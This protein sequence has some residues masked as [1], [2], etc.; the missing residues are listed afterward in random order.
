MADSYRLRSLTL[1]GFRAYLAPKTFDFGT[2]R[3]L[4]VFA[5]NGKGKSSIVDGLEFMFS[6]EGTLERLGIRTIHN[7]A[8]VVALAHNLAADRGIDSSV[9]VKFTCGKEE[10]SGKRLTAGARRRPAAAD[11]V[12]TGFVVDPIVRGY[13]LRQFVEKRTAED[14]YEDVARWLELGSLV[15]AQNSLRE[16]RRKIKAAA[17]DPQPLKQIDGQLS[18]KTGNAVRAWHDASVLAYANK[19]IAALNTG[20]SLSTLDPADPTAVTISERAEAEAKQLGLEGLRQIRRAAASLAEQKQSKDGSHVVGLIAEFEADITT[21]AAAAEKVETEKAIAADAIFEDVW[22][23]AEPLFAEGAEAPDACPICAT[24]IAE[25]KAGSVENIRAHIAGHRA[26]LVAYADARKAFENAATELS[27][28][29]TRF[30]AALKALLPL[31]P[32]ARATLKQDLSTYL[33]SL[34]AWTEGDPPNSAVLIGGLLACLTELDNEIATI[35]A[36]QG[37]NTYTKV[38]AKLTELIELRGDRLLAQRKLD[39][40]TKLHAALVEQSGFIS[41]QIRKKVQAVLD[42]LQTPVNTIYKEIQRDA[43]AP[44][45]LELPAEEDLNQQRLHLVVDF[46]TNRTG[47]QPSGYLSDS[48]IHSLALALRL[49]AIKRC[50]VT[51]PLVVL[52]DIVTSYDADHRLAFSALLAKEFADL[53]IIVVT[54]D[55]RFFIYL[56]DHLGDRDWHYIRIMQL[57]PAYGPRFVDHR[58]SDEM[59]EARWAAG[60]SAANDMRQAE[61]EW[62]LGICREFGVDVRIRTVERAYSYERSELAEALARFLGS[63]GLTPPTVPGV[64]NRFLASLQQG[65]VENFGSHFQDAQYGSGSIGDE[66]A[67][68][69]EF[70]YFRD[71]FTC[72]ACGRKRFKRPLAVNKPI[73]S[74]EKCEAQFAF[75][76]QTTPSSEVA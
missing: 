28:L 17:E 41:A 66:K 62:L 23:S 51:V 54:H 55:E 11:T 39:E 69:A 33:A 29:Q 65:V 14:R 72:P 60:E 42:T 10:L 61:E 57:D 22:K 53:Q 20:L 9:D 38:Q 75:S 6:D 12:K 24:P 48:Q 37:E 27:K 2:K 5:P 64:N 58:V 13:E 59:I 46:A 63:R 32:E 36:K 3:N 74:A 34:E 70:K 35:E 25:T 16:L 15:D 68:W 50:N 18:K 4:A 71:Q 30:V 8:G 21:K 26:E 1:S 76:G 73:C 44:I 47:V 52:D 7:Q 49:A 67:R 45:R 40:L 19:L 43:A 31:L 56:K